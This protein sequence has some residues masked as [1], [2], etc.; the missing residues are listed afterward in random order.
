MK[1][2][3]EHCDGSQHQM[4]R[5]ACATALASFYALLEQ[6]PRRMDEDELA[7]LSKAGR[8]ICAFYAAISAQHAPALWKLT[9]K[10]HLLLHLVDIQAPRWGNP[11]YFW[12]Y[13]DED[14]V[15]HVVE[16]ARS[17]HPATVESVALYKHCVVQSLC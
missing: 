10:F 16:V 1:L 14:L 13:Q 4:F 9:P 11:R 5:L 17:C 15:G 3:T 12:C 6:C 7:E 8:E 2:C